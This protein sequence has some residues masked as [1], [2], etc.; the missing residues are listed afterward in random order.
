M[1]RPIVVTAKV[2]EAGKVNTGLVEIEVPSGAIF[3]AHGEAVCGMGDDYDHQI[4]AQL[5]LATALRSLAAQ[6]RRDALGTV[7]H[8]AD[9]KRRKEVKKMA[10]YNMARLSHPLADFV[11]EIFSHRIK[12]DLELFK[13]RPP[14]SV[15][16]YRV[17]SLLERVKSTTPFDS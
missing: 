16:S 1:V 13:E 14:I 17:P 15:H 7:N 12:T 8:R 3:R 2:V 11:P 4:G 5:A 10:K 6:L 9:V